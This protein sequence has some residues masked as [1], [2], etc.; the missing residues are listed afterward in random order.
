MTGVGKVKGV[1][2]S[3]EAM[4]RADKYIPIDVEDFHEVFRMEELIATSKLIELPIFMRKFPPHQA[5]KNDS[6]AE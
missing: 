1:R 3:C 5:W 6:A 2:I 4:F